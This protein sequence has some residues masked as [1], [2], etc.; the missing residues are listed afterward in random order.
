MNTTFKRCRKKILW[1]SLF[2]ILTA[3]AVKC[4]FLFAFT[5]CGPLSVCTA[6]TTVAN[7]SSA[8]LYYPCTIK[9]PLPATTLTSGYGAYHHVLWWLARNI[10]SNGF[11]V[12]GMTPLDRYGMNSEWRDVHLSGIDKLKSLNSESGLLKGKIAIDKLQVCGH[13]KGGGGALMAA[14]ILGS[15]LKSTIA[16]CPWREEFNS[17]SGIRAPTLIQSGKR[18]I[19]ARHEMTLSEF[20]LLP[21]GIGKAYF[22]YTSASH[23]SWGVIGS[24]RLHPIL[25][26]DI[27]AWMKY[28]LEGDI[29]QQINLASVAG[30]SMNLWEHDISDCTVFTGTTQPEPDSNSSNATNR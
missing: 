5:G 30:K 17:L 25:S 20:N 2:F 14:D 7:T 16:M 12:L 27:V 13:S 22:E 26:A 1:L 19:Y 23:F 11:V 18:D 8:T 6:D 4:I 24:G 10:A 3:L 29:S 15:E 21:K 9:A 28:Y